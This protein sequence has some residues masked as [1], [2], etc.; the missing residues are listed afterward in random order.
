MTKRTPYLEIILTVAV[1]AFVALVIAGGFNQGG[2][3]AS[4]VSMRPQPTK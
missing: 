2:D 3:D 4:R 1:L